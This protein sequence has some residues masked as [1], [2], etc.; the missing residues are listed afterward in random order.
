MSLIAHGNGSLKESSLAAAL[1][2]LEPSYAARR[3]S[4]SLESLAGQESSNMDLGSYTDH[5]W[6][7]IQVRPSHERSAASLLDSKGYEAFL[8]L[9]ECRRRPRGVLV[10]CPLFPGY[11]FCRFN[12][13][14]G[15]L[16]VTTPNVV[17]IVGAGRT[18]IAIEDDEVSAIKAIVRSGCPR[19]PWPRL[20][21]GQAVRI[22]RG[23]LTGLRGIVVA[24]KGR[25][26]LVVSVNLLQRAVAVEIDQAW[27]AVLR[28]APSSPCRVGSA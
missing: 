21:T 23:P 8:P 1:S 14:I 3:M 18:P 9:Y 7:A 4:P 27:V 5:H 16:I 10:E 24:E 11:L 28:Q 15:S 26:R 12:P 22:D 25:Q 20:E 2:T 17:R 6:F 19:E 13:C